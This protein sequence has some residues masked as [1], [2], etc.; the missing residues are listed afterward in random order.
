MGDVGSGFLGFVLSLFALSDYGGTGMNLWSWL[1]L[2]GIFVVDATVTLVRRIWRG[3][4][5]YLAH[6]S[7]AYQILSRRCGSHL[8]VTSGA[9]V[10]NIVWLL[11]FAFLAAKYNEFAIVFFVIALLPIVWGTV[12][13]GAGTAGC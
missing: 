13:V 2:S 4:R 11:P 3:E 6:R 7:H 10:I 5:F 8:K 1:I 9:L 12:R